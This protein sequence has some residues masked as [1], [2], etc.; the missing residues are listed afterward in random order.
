MSFEL[1]SII[2][3]LDGSPLWRKLALSRGF[4]MLALVVAL[5]GIAWVWVD[6]QGGLEAARAHFGLWAAA[7]T[8]PL[9]AVV[10]VTPFPDEVIGLGNSVIYGFV[11][12]AILNWIGWMMGSFIEYGIAARSARDFDIRS[13]RIAA[14]FPRLHRRFPPEH[15]AFLILARLLPIG[16]GHLVNATSGLFRVPLWRFAWTG[17]IGM[18]PGSIAIAAFANGIASWAA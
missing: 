2:P 1:Q 18:I 11:T 12:G 17:A 16:G 3:G 15:P 10:A 5:G 4:Q 13:E 6:S 9:Q 14:R 8:V 7:F